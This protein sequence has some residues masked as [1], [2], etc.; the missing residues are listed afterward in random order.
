[1]EANNSLL[2]VL[3]C[4]EWEEVF[5]HCRPQDLLSLRATCRAAADILERSERVW[6]AKMRESFGLSLK[7]G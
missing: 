7:V 6:A 2:S 5:M 4:D 3:N 1:M